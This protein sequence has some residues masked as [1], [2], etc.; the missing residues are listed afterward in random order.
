MAL[1]GEGDDV[2]GECGDS[3]VVG[4]DCLAY[5]SPSHCLLLAAANGEYDSIH[6]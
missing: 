1:N 4:G 3:V 2:V 5:L 6:F